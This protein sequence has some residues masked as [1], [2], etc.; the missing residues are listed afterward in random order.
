MSLLKSLEYIVNTGKKVSFSVEIPRNL[1]VEVFLKKE[2]ETYKIR[3]C[4]PLDDHF[5]EEKIIDL[6]EWMDKEI[7]K[8]CTK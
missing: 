2:E 4:L 5:Y 1:T 7:K 8:Q 6:I 3:Q